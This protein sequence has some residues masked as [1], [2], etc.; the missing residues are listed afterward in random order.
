MVDLLLGGGAAAPKP[1]S[2]KAAPA[3]TTS[4]DDLPKGSAAAAKPASTAAPPDSKTAA[5]SRPLPNPVASPTT[6]ATDRP[7]AR[8]QFSSDPSF[9][10][11]RQIRD[12]DG[13]P[14]GALGVPL[15]P[16][17]SI[18]VDPRTTPLG[19]PV[20]IASDG[21]GS[22]GMRRLML[23]Q[24]TGGA[25]RGAVR[26]DYFWG[27]GPQAGQRASQTKAVGR[28]WLL[29]P[30]DLALGTLPGSIATRGL[31]R[32]GIIDLDGECVIADPDLCVE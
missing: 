7:P 10:F 29:V 17:R 30:K 23:A 4:A 14:I 2:T 24:D 19:M 11:F 13:G 8:T 3:K 21:A 12:Y 26:A 16:Q 31:D 20:Y 32:R 1:A 25:I 27:F 28:M 15:T 22:S 6:T 9:V 18:A 5:A